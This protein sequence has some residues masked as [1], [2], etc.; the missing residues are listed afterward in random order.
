MK[1]FFEAIGDLFTN[2]LFYPL[3]VLRETE[4]TNWW[5]ANTVSWVFV[6]IC[7]IAFVYWMN[8]LKIFNNSGEEE[9]DVSAH[10][11]L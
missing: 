8:Q 7:C 11:Y 2:Y 1:A 5:L 4:L 6:L 3:D 10:S 9:N